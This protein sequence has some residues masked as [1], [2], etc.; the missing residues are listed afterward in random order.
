MEEDRL[1]SPDLLE[2][3]SSRFSSRPPV[4]KAKEGEPDKPTS[5]KFKELKGIFPSSVHSNVD[6]SLYLNAV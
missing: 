2:G 3:L 1:V 5:K 4:K 6:Y